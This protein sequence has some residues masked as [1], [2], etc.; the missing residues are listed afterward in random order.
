MQRVSVRVQEWC[1]GPR[2]TWLRWRAVC[3]S[4]GTQMGFPSGLPGFS[5]VL[6]PALTHLRAMPTQIS[7]D[8]PDA[9][10]RPSAANLRMLR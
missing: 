8:E 3:R 1:T 5:C 9:E 4:T 7:G 10:N 2:R 6:V